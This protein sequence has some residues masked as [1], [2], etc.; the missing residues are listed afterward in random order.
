MFACIGRRCTR[1]NSQIDK[2]LNNSKSSDLSVSKRGLLNLVEYI[3]NNDDKIRYC[4]K[5]DAAKKIVDSVKRNEELASYGCLA[6]YYMAKLRPEGADACMKAGAPLM[7]VAAIMSNKEDVNI[8]INACDLLTKLVESSDINK[9]IIKGM[10]FGQHQF[11]ITLFIMFTKMFHEERET[12][13][14]KEEED[15]DEVLYRLNV[16]SDVLYDDASEDDEGEDDEE[17]EGEDPRETPN[18]NGEG[19]KNENPEK[20]GEGGRRRRKSATQKKKKT[21][22]RYTRRGLKYV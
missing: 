7:A 16:L 9:G 12:T 10:K 15:K 22:R 18:A 17:E 8:C 11:P 13:T 3:K 21:K 6:L 5:H 19:S 4:V 2:A 1:K 20:P 14:D